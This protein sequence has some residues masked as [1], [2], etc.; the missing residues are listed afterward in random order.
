MDCYQYCH[1]GETP[2][3]Y[4]PQNFPHA[5]ILELVQTLCRAFLTNKKWERDEFQVICHAVY[6]LQIAVARINWEKPTPRIAAWTSDTAQALGFRLTLGYY[7][8]GLRGAQPP[9]VWQMS[10]RNI[11]SWVWKFRSK[12]AMLGPVNGFTNAHVA[13]VANYIRDKLT[14]SLTEGPHDPADRCSKARIGNEVHKRA[15]ITNY[16]EPFLGPWI[17]CP[18]C[19]QIQRSKQAL[20]QHM[21]KWH[22]VAREQSP[23][24]ITDWKTCTSNF[25]MKFDQIWYCPMCEFNSKSTKEMYSHVIESGAHTPSQLLFMGFYFFAAEPEDFNKLAFQIYR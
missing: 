13:R 22:L 8:D 21:S 25:A 14:R 24:C 17:H 3:D 2:Q 12:L 6:K 16:I 23:K 10:V 15:S 5:A 11:E 1:G 4:T 18:I 20:T 9:S 19:F 7:T